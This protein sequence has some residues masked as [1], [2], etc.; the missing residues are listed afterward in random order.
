[1][2]G[3][4]LPNDYFEGGAKAFFDY[5]NLQV[6]YSVG[7][8]PYKMLHLGVPACP[9]K[10]RACDTFIA[11]HDFRFKAFLGFLSNSFIRY[12]VVRM[13]IKEKC[14]KLIVHMR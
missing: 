2:E 3:Q 14:N 8:K 4:Y 5:L 10:L 9:L 13:H 12:D 7:A 11:F 1:M 6:D